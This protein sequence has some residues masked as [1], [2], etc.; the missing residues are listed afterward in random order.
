MPV[1]PLQG[2]KVIDCS[3]G[4][5]GA[6]ATGI[7]CDYGATV[8]RVEP[9]GGDPWRRPLVVPYAAYNR[10]K[11]SVELDPAASG[12]RTDLLTLLAAADLV[13][14]SGHPG[15]FERIGLGYQALHKEFPGLI[16]TSITGFGPDGPQASLPGYEAIVHAVVG[17]LG[18]QPGHRDPPVYE[19]LPFAGIGAGY[20]AVIGSLAALHRRFDDGLG[21]LVETSMLDGALAYLSM[22]WSDDDTGTSWKPGGRRLISRAYQCADG[23]YLGIHT[24]A[25][26]AFDRLMDVLGLSAHFAGAAENIGA[27]LDEHQEAVVADEVPKILA[28]RPRREWLEALRDADVCAIP[29]LHPGQ[30]FDEPQVRH[31]QMVVEVDDLVLGPVQQVAPAA[32]FGR[33]A[34]AP[35]VPRPAPAAGQDNAHLGELVAAPS[36]H[37]PRQPPRA[38]VGEPLLAGVK[39]L[40]LGAFYAGPYGSRLLADLGADVIKVEPLRGDQLRGLKQPFGSAQAGKLGVAIDLKDAR[41][42]ELAGSLVAWA[43]VIQHNMRPGAAERVG[44]GYDDVCRINPEVVYAYSPGWGSTG[45]DARRQSFAPLVSGYVGVNYEVAGQFNPPVYPAGNEDPGNGLLG[46]VVMLI[47]LLHR[48]RTGAG[49]YVEHPQLNAAMAHVAHIVRR[50]GGEV[51]G[52]NRLDPLQHGVGALDRLYETADGW[53]C[54]V[55][56]RDE[57]VAGLGRAL[58]V[59]LAKDPRFGTADARA[60]HDYE[61]AQLLSGAL[62]ELTTE[63]AVETLTRAGV[64]A[65]APV[66]RNDRTFLRDPENRR[67]GR[68]AECPHPDRGHVRELAVLVRVS[69]AEARPH[70]LAPGLGEH[71]DEILTMLGIGPEAIAALRADGMIR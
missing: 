40:D 49:S 48:R 71:T 22:L 70:R 38:I 54:V 34:W 44:V 64:P 46:A 66:P 63:A 8:I 21:R 41:T 35:A 2:L 50:P 13:V 19:G 62:A 36:W 51:L 30:V 1:G 16:Y 7:L 56:P 45:P 5:A 58:G 55:A 24:G 6:F 18:E 27:L 29:E 4:T 20:L 43:D 39:V 57:H 37:D 59:D 42:R 12:G 60:E 26:G 47:G 33:G 52:A 17:T 23:E 53:I 14:V 69:D 31:N 61:L 15:T 32:R 3:R 68:V 25:V 11:A 65:T 28:T 10:G 67:T 9:P